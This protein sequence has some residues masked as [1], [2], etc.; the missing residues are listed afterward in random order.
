MFWFALLTFVTVGGLCVA[1]P[2]CQKKHVYVKWVGLM[3]TLSILVW[4][5]FN[6]LFDGPPRILRSVE[7]NL[8]H[9]N[10]LHNWGN[11]DKCHPNTLVRAK[12]ED[13]VRAAMVHDRVRVAG[14]GHSWTP[15]KP[16][17]G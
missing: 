7:R 3:W 11:T 17:S 9:G 15:I 2:W 6:P 14:A 5:V 10:T 8:T 1:I 4:Y 16:T 13:D 12:H